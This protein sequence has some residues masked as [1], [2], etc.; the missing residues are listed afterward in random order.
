MPRVDASVLPWP[1]SRGRIHAADVEPVSLCP[2]VKT[3][4]LVAYSIDA[5]LSREV[6]LRR[7]A[8]TMCR[9]SFIHRIWRDATRSDQNLP[10]ATEG[11]LAAQSHEP[12]MFARQQET[13]YSKA[14]VAGSN[15]AGGTA[16][17]W[18]LAALYTGI[19]RLF[20]VYGAV[21]HVRD[22]GVDAAPGHVT[23]PVSSRSWNAQGG[24]RRSA[25]TS[26]RRR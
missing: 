3:G 5:G 25:R 8:Q 21:E 17:R 18:Y 20:I 24:W 6:A 12:G 10:A 2:E 23:C 11:N 4:R 16:Q 19:H 1:R 22:G 26:P 9:S 7:I 13:T 14:G 15:P